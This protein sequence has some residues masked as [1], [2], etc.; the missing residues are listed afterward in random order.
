M[1]NFKELKVWEMSHEFCLKIYRL[2]EDLPKEEK[3]GLVSQLRRASSSIPINISEGCGYDTNP[4]FRRYLKIAAGS[5]SEV[6]YCLILVKDLGYISLDTYKDL[7]K[8]VNSIKK[9]LFKF[10]E[11]LK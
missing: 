1:R 9:M 7:D 2:I 6:E 3:Y 5:T 4:E 10:I 11:K 8:E